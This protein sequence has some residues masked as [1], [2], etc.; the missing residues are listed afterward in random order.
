MLL[1][2]LFLSVVRAMLSITIKSS[3]L[4]VKVSYRVG[5]YIGHIRYCRVSFR[6]V[7]QFSAPCHLL[8]C[9]KLLPMVLR[10]RLFYI[11]ISQLPSIKNLISGRYDR[12]GGV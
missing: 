1:F 2:V 10:R 4:P 6:F 7:C 8:I 12:E 3:K 11:A 9:E 5:N